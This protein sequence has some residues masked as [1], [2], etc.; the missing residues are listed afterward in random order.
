MFLF[1]NSVLKIFFREAGSREQGAARRED[2]GGGRT[3]GG[4]ALAGEQ[5]WG[6]ALAGAARLS[7]NKRLAALARE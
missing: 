1:C 5:P 4:A 6:A 7:R 3:R 2:P